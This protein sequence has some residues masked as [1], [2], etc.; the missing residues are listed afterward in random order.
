MAPPFIAVAVN[1]T[2]VPVQIALPALEEMVIE[3]TIEVVVDMVM[4][5]LVAVGTV[6]H[7]FELVSKQLTTS[8][9]ARA[10]LL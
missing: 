7:K 3:G 4:L 10:L 1:V 2:L 8:P 9:F 5:L 6:E